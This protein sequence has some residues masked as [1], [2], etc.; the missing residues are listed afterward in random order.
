MEIQNGAMRPEETHSM[1]DEECDLAH[2]LVC[3]T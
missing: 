1:D 3:V 2:C